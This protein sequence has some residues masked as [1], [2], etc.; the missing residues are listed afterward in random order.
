MGQEIDIVGTWR[1]NK[2]VAFEMGLSG[3][4]PAE[5]MKSRFS[6]S[7]VSTWGYLSASVTF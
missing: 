1:Y 4:L 6:G 2:H 5:I 7:D 3:F